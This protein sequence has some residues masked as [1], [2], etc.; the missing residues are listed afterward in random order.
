MSDAPFVE[1]IALCGTAAGLVLLA[2]AKA[3]LG[4]RSLLVRASATAGCVLAAGG[5][6]AAVGFPALAALPCGVV[7]AAAV[8][9]ALAG[10]ARVAS[11]WHRF[12]GRSVHAGCLAAVGGV[13]F[14]G[15][16]SRYE[17]ADEAAI[18][19]DMAH[20]LD[21]TWKPPLAEATEVAATT[22]LGRPVAMHRPTKVRPPAEVATAEARVIGTVLAT[23]GA[24]RTGPA[25]DEFNCHGW[26][27]S[28]GRYWVSPTDIETILADNGYRPVSDP[29]AG[30]L[31]VYREGERITHTGVVRTGG[32]GEPV[33]VESKW[34]WL[35][36]FLHPPGAT[37]YG[38][39]F[40]YYR[41]ARAGH[42]LAGLADRTVPSEAAGVGTD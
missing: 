39:S 9:S 14:V 29:R 16:L 41:S 23:D 31:V 28:G 18:D 30:D 42:V 19:R 11:A 37:C 34:G 33:I 15:S 5:L 38:R 21:V 35:G 7:T 3:T 10:S 26:V 2:L 8:A 4:G 24:I 6:P 20:M 12:Q 17:S 32:N 25:A 36:Q 27:F 40:T 13:L 22:D 1:L